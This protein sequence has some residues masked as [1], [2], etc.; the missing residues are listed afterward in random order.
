V[1]GTQWA[2]S[3]F[4]LLSS[5]VL[6]SCD[7]RS[8]PSKQTLIGGHDRSDFLSEQLAYTSGPP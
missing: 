3:V 5:A 6:G 1:V 2:S 4:H 8:Y 7:V